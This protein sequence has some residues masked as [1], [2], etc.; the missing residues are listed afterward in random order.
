MV[1]WET[2]KGAI[3][4]PKETFYAFLYFIELI[5][6]NINLKII[7]FSDTNT[8]I[9]ISW[10]IPKSLST[11]FSHFSPSGNFSETQSLWKSLKSSPLS[12]HCSSDT[13]SVSQVITW[14]LWWIQILQV[15][16]HLVKQFKIYEGMER[17]CL[18]TDVICFYCCAQLPSL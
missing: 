14:S 16:I 10:P 3:F 13:N 17:G 2:F 6:Y 9:T 11:S 12:D 15:P 8:T 18:I 1:R 7:S 4:L 5:N